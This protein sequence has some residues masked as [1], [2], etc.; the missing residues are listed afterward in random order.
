MLSRRGVIPLPGYIVGLLRRVV[1]LVL[2]CIVVAFRYVVIVVSWCTVVVCIVYR[3]MQ[4]SG[5]K[6]ETRSAAGATR[7]VFEP[8]LSACDPL[9]AI[10]VSDFGRTGDFFIMAIGDSVETATQFWGILVSFQFTPVGGCQQEVTSSDDVLF[11]FDAFKGAGACDWS[12]VGPTSMSWGCVYLK[13][14]LNPYLYATSQ[15]PIIAATT[16]QTYRKLAA[17]SRI[18]HLPQ[19]LP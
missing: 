3:R 13:L 18:F 16:T 19:F 14:R 10:A 9:P 5:S 17:Q 11:K 8:R 15:S 12:K 6:G 7:V 2:W 4:S 1:I